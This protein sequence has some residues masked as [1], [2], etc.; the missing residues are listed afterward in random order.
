[1]VSLV[2]SLL[3][4]P[5]RAAAQAEPNEPRSLDD[6]GGTDAS[7]AEAGDTSEEK[8]G[9]EEKQAGEATTSPSSTLTAPVLVEEL[10]VPYPSDALAQGI[11]GEV[12]LELTLSAE[13]RV[14][15]SE[16]LTTPHP[17]L[18]AALAEALA[19][20]KFEPARRRGEA[21]GAKIRF[22][23][24]FHAPSRSSVEEAGAA[25]PAALTAPSEGLAPLQEVVSPAPPTASAPTVDVQVQVQ[26]QSMGK[27]L[28]KSAQAVQV[29]ELEEARARSADLGDILARSGGVTVRRLGGLGSNASLNMAGLGGEQLRVF[30]DGLPIDVSGFSFGI[31]NVP[32]NWVDRVEIYQGVVPIRFGA[33][34]LGG[35]IQLVTDQDLRKNRVGVS[36]Q[37]GS[38][39]TQRAT[40]GAQV[41]RP[42]S[43]LVG[44]VAGYV[45][46]TENNYPVHVELTDSAGQLTPGVVNRFHDGYTAGGAQLSVGVVDK[47]YAK[48]LIGTAFI[49]SFD[50]DIQSNPSMSVPYGE[51]TFGKMTAGGNVRY[52]H[53]LSK[54]LKLNASLAYAYTGTRFVDVASCRYDWRGACFVD[55]APIRGEIRQVPMNVTVND[56]TVLGRAE[57]AYSVAEHHELRF[58][59]APNLALRN[60]DDAERSG[61][62]YDALNRTQVLD[63]LVLGSE[64]QAELFQDRLE[65]IAFVKGYGQHMQ[66]EQLLAT[67]ELD[68]PSRET[69][70]FGAGD[71]LRFNFTQ[72]LWGKVS[73]E[74]ATR[75]PSAT[76]VFGDGGL[77]TRNLEL[78]PEESDNVNL[79]VELDAPRTP[80]GAFS[81]KLFGFGRFTSNQIILLNL[82]TYLQYENVLSARTLGAEAK[83]GWESPGR[84]ISLGGNSVYQD[85]RN[86]SAEG[87]MA[88]FEGDRLPNRPYMQASFTAAARLFDLFVKKDE[89]SLRF[90]SFYV[91]EF[92][93]AW[94]SA[95]NESQKLVVPSQLT[96]SLALTHRLNGDKYD[97]TTSAEVLNLTDERVFDFYGAER[98]GRTFFLKVQ[99]QRSN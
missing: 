89:L 69:L 76:E 75:L 3:A 14:I 84:F 22:A 97:F 55:L 8:K 46:T 33:D 68:E 23:Y 90:E 6:A 57:L 18:S 83:L 32:V 49:G 34:A 54:D 40:L 25:A 87:P 98:P 85:V 2:G 38:F 56:H 95:G 94:E 91:H 65:N 48:R 99:L 19:E 50:R 96:H 72:E 66:S 47:P 70:R 4:L 16:T 74:R 24:E 52:V 58:A 43:G 28:E 11:E 41:Y 79:S 42:K 77:T 5:P 81:A 62:Q 35:A 53:S 63:S 20:V 61:Q 31:A 10:Q 86:T 93:R 29:I 36:Y 78:I 7:G 73:F 67:G 26:G 37:V 30:V 51:V 59:L 21:V 13:G 39:E 71:S 88:Q 1:V 17:S 27:A 45:D 60:G 80:L 64:W 12:V 44:R 82:G 9:G 15:S 92:F